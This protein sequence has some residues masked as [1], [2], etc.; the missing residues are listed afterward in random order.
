M[1]ALPLSEGQETQRSNNKKREGAFLLPVSFLNF[2]LFVTGIILK[3]KND[4]GIILVLQSTN[5]RLTVPTHCR[6]TVGLIG[7]NEFEAVE[8]WLYSF[9]DSVETLQEEEQSLGLLKHFLQEE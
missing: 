3:Y 5:K 8:Q 1:L 6:M 9:M 2:V 4:T 7:N